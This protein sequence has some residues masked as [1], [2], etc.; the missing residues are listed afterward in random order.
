MTFAGPTV[1][2]LETDSAWI[3]IL[4]VSFATLA[5]AIVLR[6]V[7][8][9]P[10]GIASSA[11][12]LT[13]LVL[14][15]VAGVV[16]QR[17]LLPEV[18]VLQPFGTAIQ[19][20]S[21]QLFHL[22]MVNDGTAMVPYAISGRA[23]PYIFLIGAAMVAFM[24]IRRA[25]GML[26]VGR[27]I[28]RC[29]PSDDTELLSVVRRL[30]QAAELTYVPE[31][32]ILPPSISGAFAAGMRR[33]KILISRDLLEQL[34][35]AELT[36]ILAHEIAHL[37]SRDVPV[38]VMAG[39]LRDLVVWNPFAHI[40]LRKLVRD[41]ESEADRRAAALTGDPLSV[42]SGLLRIVEVASNRRTLGQRAVL[43]FWRPGNSISRRVNDLIA[44]ADGRASVVDAS[45]LPFMVATLL[46]GL[47]G[48]QVAE[49]IAAE[50]PGALAIVWGAPAE[51]QGQIWEV[52]KRIAKAAGRPAR[53]ATVSGRGKQKR[54]LAL[55]VRSLMGPN[56][57][58]KPGDLPLWMDAV[59]E[60]IKGLSDA[61][62]RWEA[63]QNWMAEPLFEGNVGPRIGIYRIDQ[64]L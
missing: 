61:T 60:R 28:M 49:R 18:S 27:L 30:A 39:L 23:G 11:L 46:V 8:A 42:A 19:E 31:I 50:N 63:R 24:L 37:R 25:T 17:G 53:G 62:L 38:V 59:S 57:R 2:T 29:S 47:V 58:V 34:E 26:L 12:L 54:D 33:G 35:P 45:K 52:P 43:A 55:P 5:A 32:L 9:R 14:P 51:E 64:Q 16:Y 6:K 22:L 3:V 4:A 36:G 13:P 41:R 40:A 56:V 20:H 1:L 21:H 10:G 48:L 44:V 15:I 7:L